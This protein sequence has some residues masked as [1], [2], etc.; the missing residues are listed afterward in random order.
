M[1]IMAYLRNSKQSCC[2]SKTPMTKLVSQNS[3]NLLGFALLNQGIIDDNMLLPW[4][5]KEIGITMS[6][7]LASINDVKLGERELQSLGKILNAG[8]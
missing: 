1:R 6:A 4:H 3:N 5:T 8:L 2:V 7:S